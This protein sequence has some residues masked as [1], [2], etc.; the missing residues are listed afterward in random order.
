MCCSSTPRSREQRVVPARGR[1]SPEY[2]ATDKPRCAGARRGPAPIAP[3]AESDDPRDIGSN[4]WVVAGSRTQSTFPIL[5]NDP[6][7]AIAAPSLRYW[8][9]LVAPGWNVIGGG[10]PVLPGVSI[11]H[12]EHGAWGL[13]IF[14]SDNEDLYVYE[15]NPANPNEYR[16]RG[17]WEAMRVVTTRSRSKGEKPRGRGAEVH[18]ARSGD[19]SRIA[20]IARP[21]RCAPAWMEPGGAPYLASLRMDQATT[22]EEFREALHLQPDAVGEHGLGRSRRHHRL[23]GRRHP[24]A[25]QELERPAA[26]AGRRPLRVGRLPADRGAAA[27]GESGARLH[28]DREQLSLPDQLPGQGRSCTC[29]GPI[30]IRASRITEV[31]G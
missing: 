15:T 22:W 20:P 8:V 28:R 2:R 17:A 13:T 23:A 6:H 29:S 7:R 3:A 25:A 27:R 21:T 4:N 12:N 24:A 9:H 19:C 5:A 10:E 11:G 14:G 31:L 1:R 26:R 30:R 18:A 16:Y